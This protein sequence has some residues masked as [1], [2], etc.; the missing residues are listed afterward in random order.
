M[1]AAALCHTHYATPPRTLTLRIASPVPYFYIPYLPSPV[2]LLRNSL[3]AYG[4]SPSCAVQNCARA[5]AHFTPRFARCIYGCSCL[6]LPL[7]VWFAAW[8]APFRCDFSCDRCYRQTPRVYA[9]LPRP[10]R[11]GMPASPWR[12]IRNL[13]TFSAIIL[14]QVLPSGGFPCLYLTTPLPFFPHL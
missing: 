10:L 12:G 11:I 6:V 7:P 8:H 13:F 2:L 14:P 5:R 1:R 9:T 3:D 4:D